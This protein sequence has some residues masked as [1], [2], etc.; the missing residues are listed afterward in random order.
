MVVNCLPPLFP[1]LPHTGYSQIPHTQIYINASFCITELLVT[2]SGKLPD[3]PDQKKTPCNLYMNPLP[4]HFETASKHELQQLPI[5]FPGSLS[6]PHCLSA[7][8]PS[9]LSCATPGECL[10]PGAHPP[11]QSREQTHSPVLS[12]QGS[13]G[14]GAPETPPAPA[15]GQ[16]EEK[17]SSWKSTGRNL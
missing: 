10:R 6:C 16:A 9:I 14:W 4:L 5:P 11:A 7:L 2:I 1:G 15:P 13:R 8:A 12:L 17:I 3:V